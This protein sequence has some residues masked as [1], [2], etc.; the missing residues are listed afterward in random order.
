M[1]PACEVEKRNEEIKQEFC[2]F[3]NQQKLSF[4]F[5]LTSIFQNFP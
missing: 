3:L 1:N 5:A 2:H 4:V